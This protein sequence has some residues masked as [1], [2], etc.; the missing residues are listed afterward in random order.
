MNIIVE[1]EASFKTWLSGKKTI[2]QEMPSGQ[3]ENTTETAK[4]KEVAALVVH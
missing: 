1:D 4:V 2:A 3:A